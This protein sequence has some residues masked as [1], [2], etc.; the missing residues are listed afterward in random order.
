[1]DMLAKYCE[2]I[3][4]LSVFL[5]T[6]LHLSRSDGAATLVSARQIA[7][8]LSAESAETPMKT[9]GDGRSEDAIGGVGPVHMCHAPRSTRTA[10]GHE[11][12]AH[13]VWFESGCIPRS[14]GVFDVAGCLGL[15]V[16]GIW[17]RNSLALPVQLGTCCQE[18][19][20]GRPERPPPVAVDRSHSASQLEG[21]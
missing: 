17:H 6:S 21:W 7:G 11:H 5:R 9:P 19:R 14:L 1:M 3:D 13:L 2:C 18:P 4:S 10:H 15:V 16:F 20:S 8:V 12:E